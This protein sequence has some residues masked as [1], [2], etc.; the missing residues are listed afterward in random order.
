[1]FGVPNQLTLILGALAIVGTFALGATIGYKI[2]AGR[3]AELKLEYTQAEVKAREEAAS[4]QKA[5]DDIALGAAQTEASVQQAQASL[6]ERQINEVT[7]HV[8]PTLA[9][10]A[11]ASSPRACISYGLVRVLDAAALGD[12][13]TDLQLP[14]GQSDDTCTNLTAIDLA[15]NVVANYGAARENAEQLNRLELTIIQ[16]QKASNAPPPNP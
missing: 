8:S 11:R 4:I 15:R 6:T 16:L 13:P 1:M 14:A 3:V 5:Q 12:D 7:T 2:E 9:L 10:S